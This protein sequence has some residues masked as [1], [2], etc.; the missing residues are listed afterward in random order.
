M[1]CYKIWVHPQITAPHRPRVT[2]S[3]RP[4]VLEGSLLVMEG[5]GA[6][7]R[8]KVLD[9]VL[10]RDSEALNVGSSPG[11]RNCLGGSSRREFSI[12]DWLSERKKLKIVVRGGG[13]GWWVWFGTCLVWGPHGIPRNTFL[14]PSKSS[15]LP[16][17]LNPLVPLSLTSLWGVV[18]W[19]IWKNRWP[20]AP[21]PGYIVQSRSRSLLYI[22]TFM[23]RHSQ[24]MIMFMWHWG[25]EVTIQVTLWISVV[26]MVCMRCSAPWYGL[27]VPLFS[28]LLC[29][30]CLPSKIMSCLIWT[31]VMS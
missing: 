26:R 31:G 22:L 27:T 20:G 21:C 29:A 23:S 16:M 15:G 11:I 28:F 4:V 24:R 18:L 1:T 8:L 17:S 7:T 6:D 13:G 30:F 10:V 5:T 2:W 3:V 9:F 25:P 19:W 14:P 12:G